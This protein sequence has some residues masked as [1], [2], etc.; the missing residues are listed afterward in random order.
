MGGTEFSTA[1]VASTNIVLTGQP[2]A[3]ATSSAPLSPTS[4]NRSG[5]TTPSSHSARISAGGGGTSIFTAAPS[6]QTGV[7]GIPSGAQPSPRC[8]TSPSTPPPTTPA[9]LYC[10][11]DNTSTGITGS[12]TNG[13]R[14]SIHTMDLT[15][16]GGTSFT[17][18]IFA[19][20]VAMINQATNST[21]Q[22]LV[23]PTLYTLAA[24][25]TTYASV[26][27]DIT[28][29]TNACTAGASYLQLRRHIAVCRRHRLRPG[30]RPRLAR[31]QQPAHRLEGKPRH[32]IH[33]ARLHH[34]P[35]RGHLGSRRLRDR[36]RHHHR[37]LRRLHQHYRSHRHRHA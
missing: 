29:G 16:A 21:G 17:V 30:H 27:H 19:G 33:A 36:R 14:D 4:P 7:P 35:R 18:P 8:P 9:T 10:S 22:G 37:R 20:M 6:W 32:P 28:S 3:A 34:N 13:F 1:D 26:F 31:L 12:C 5:T 2:P 25:S 23:N 11:S 15:V 24:N